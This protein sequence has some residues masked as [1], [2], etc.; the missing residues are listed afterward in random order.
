MV[1]AGIG[2]GCPGKPPGTTTVIEVSLQFE[3]IAAAPPI[4][5]LDAVL[6]V[7]LPAVGDVHRAPKP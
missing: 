6:Q 4:L 2:D 5:T 7:A 1:Q 3:M